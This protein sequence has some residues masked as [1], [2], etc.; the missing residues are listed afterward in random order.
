MSAGH[1]SG[2]GTGCR[3]I[4][5]AIGGAELPSI[6]IELWE[7]DD[8]GEALFP[9]GLPCGTRYNANSPW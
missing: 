9:R 6:R 5:R 8:A 2:N 4:F 3:G 7:S 1:G